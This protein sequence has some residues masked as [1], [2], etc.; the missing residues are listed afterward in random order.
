MT[1]HIER[2]YQVK[3]KRKDVLAPM[4]K[5]KPALVYCALHQ[6]FCLPFEAMH[7][8]YVFC[9]IDSFYASCKRQNGTH[10]EDIKWVKAEEKDMMI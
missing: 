3:L 2:N 4:K 7:C 5:P 1:E 9:L 8:T 10:G 6:R